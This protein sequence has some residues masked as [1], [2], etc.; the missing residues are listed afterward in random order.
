MRSVIA[1]LVLPLVLL[2]IGTGFG[3]AESLTVQDVV[4]QPG[5]YVK[6]TVTVKGLVRAKGESP[7]PLRSKNQIIIESSDKTVSLPIFTNQSYESLPKVGEVYE[8][9][10]ILKQGDQGALYIEATSGFDW[11]MV[12]LI[13]LGVVAVVLVVALL[14]SGRKPRPNDVVAVEAVSPAATQLADIRVPCISCKQPTPAT[15]RFCEVCGADQ[16]A[17]VVT[18]APVQPTAS[19]PAGP[20]DSTRV[21]VAAP[22]PTMLE[23]LIGNIYVKDG[24][25]KGKFYPIGGK[26]VTFGRDPA[27]TVAV[28]G[29]NVSRLHAEIRV[30]GSNVWLED[31]DSTNGTYVNGQRVTRHSLENGD[32]IRIGSSVLVF[33][34]R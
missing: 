24:T 19:A 34:K 33:E 12:A 21:E 10:G 8:V 5:K 11:L 30:D 22:A 15:D 13:A 6:E 31:K 25:G 7:D 16:R 2:G 3:W 20:A 1:R 4:S 14:M 18:V 32:E 27:S 17:Q 23:T 29:D 28:T 26:P 9:R